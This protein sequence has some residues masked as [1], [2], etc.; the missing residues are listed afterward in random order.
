M[1]RQLL[2]KAQSRLRKEPSQE[3]GVT[4]K[5]P[6]VHVSEARFEIMR[7]EFRRSLVF[8]LAIGAVPIRFERVFRV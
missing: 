8:C 4:L 2:R 6:M 7:T 3:S 1:L 5:S